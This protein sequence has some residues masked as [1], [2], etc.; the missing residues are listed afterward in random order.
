M[1][2]DDPLYFYIVL[3]GLYAVIL[4]NVAS[5]PEK[6]SLSQIASPNHSGTPRDKSQNFQAL[7]QKTPRHE[8]KSALQS[9]NGSQV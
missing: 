2:K 1:Q 5:E 6:K 3:K 4:Q 7:S 9:P 8:K